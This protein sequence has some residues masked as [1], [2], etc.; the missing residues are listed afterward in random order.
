MR[1][2]HDTYAVALL[3]A[4]F[5][6]HQ[7]LFNTYNFKSEFKTTANG[8]A[9]VRLESTQYMTEV[10]VWDHASCMDVQI[11]EIATEISSFPH[12]GECTT[13]QEFESELSKMLVWAKSNGDVGH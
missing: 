7:G 5:K 13:R 8:S 12:V 4:W 11:L 6:E 2:S 9:L 3:K 1:D 10:C